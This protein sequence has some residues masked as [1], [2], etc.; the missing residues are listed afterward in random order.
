M[1]FNIEAAKNAGYSDQEIQDFLQPKKERKFNVEAAKEAGYS[2]KE[3]HS[4]LSKA[5]NEP[6]TLK[7]SAGQFAGGLAGGAGGLPKDI[8]SLTN[9]I[10]E[11]A[12]KFLP[13]IDLANKAAEASGAK[14]THELTSEIT[15]AMGVGDPQ[16]A[17]ERILRESGQFG[18]QEALIGTA[19]GG[20]VAGALGAAHGSASGALYGGLK[21]LGLNDEAALAATAIA[22]ISP[23]AA[24]AYLDKRLAKQSTKLAEETPKAPKEVPVEAQAAK[25]AAPVVEE[26]ERLPSGLTKPRAVEA[27]HAHLAKISPEAQ[28]AAI[29]KLDTEASALAKATVKKHL[30]IAEEISKGVDFEAKFEKNFGELKSLMEKANPQ[31]DITPVSKLLKETYDKYRGIPS[32]HPEAIKIKKEIT[33]FVDRPQTSGK[34]LLRIFR[35]NNKKRNDIFETSRLT[36]KQQEYVDFLGDMNRAIS[37]S[38][39]RTLPSD[40]SWLKAFLENNKDFAQYKGAQKTLHTLDP[41]LRGEVTSGKVNALAHD[42]RVKKRLELSLGKEGAEEIVQIAKDLKKASESIKKIPT[43]TLS[44]FEDAY[45]IGLLVPFIQVPIVAKKGID[46]VRKAYGHYLTSPAKRA[47]L[48]KSLQALAS[49]DLAAYKEATSKLKQL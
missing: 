45:S 7:G 8:Q 48:D 6:V 11:A 24:R 32:L 34:N 12:R 35:S 1:T 5:K 10:P 36:G 22:T 38:F 44:K 23:I 42:P 17:L 40:S 4:F 3:I 27:E 33:R 18:G 41:L 49:Q 20:P 31:I 39:E 43:A 16:N 15:N 26:I 28:K 46:I 9:I 30:P 29:R 2:D 19:V 14:G 37:K 47:A 13:G 21:E 25:K